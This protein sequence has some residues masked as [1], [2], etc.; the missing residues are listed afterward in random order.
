[1]EEGKDRSSFTRITLQAVVVAVV[2]VVGFVGGIAVGAGGTGKVFSSIPLIGD[3]LDATPDESADMGDFWKAWNALDAR[4]VETHASSSIPS[5]KEKLWGAIQGL[6]DAYGDPYT[7]YMPP[8]EAKVFQDD[9]SGNFEGVGMEIGVKDDLLT[10]ISPLKG[11]PAERAGIRAGDSILSIN[12]TPT[13][14]LS[15]DEAVK[16]IRGPKGTEVRFKM[17]RE[18]EIIDITVVRDRIEVPAIEHSL[19]QASG[20]YTISFYSFTGN[21]ADLFARAVQGFKQSGSDKLL[22]D[23]R[24]NP[25][26]YL[27]AAVTIAGHFLPDGSVVVTE[28]YKGKRENIVHRSRGKGSVSADTKVVILINQGSASASEILAGALQDEGRATLIGERSFGKGSV[29]ELV[30]VGGGALKVTVA[31]WLTPKGTSISD[32]GLKPDIEVVRTQ[33]DATAGKD[34]QRERAIEF[35]KTGK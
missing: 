29:Q 20:V 16:L 22:I 6:A 8:E 12:D 7:V 21:S 28:D 1:M 19:D 26:G 32:G 2:L 11:T 30:K 23:L 5:S 35:L 14:G 15:T 33:E 18:G 13:D 31:R 4:F 25:G 10:V 3:G 9:I 27:E 24:G 34:P 17:L